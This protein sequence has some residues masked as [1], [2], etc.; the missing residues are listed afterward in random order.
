MDLSQPERF[1]DAIVTVMGLGRYSQGSGLGVTKWLLRHGAQTVITDLKDPAELQESVD[2]VMEWFEKYRVQY[3]DRT[4]YQ[5]LFILGKHREE[6]FVSV[7]CVV[8]NPG[9]PSESDFASRAKS[10]GVAIESDASLFFRYFPHP[11]IAVTGTR[12]KTTT[13]LLIGEMLKAFDSNAVVTGNIS[14]SPLE[15]LDDMLARQTPTPV[16][17]E[18]SSWMLESM[19]SAFT[20][21]QKGPDIAVITN[22]FP[23][24]L[25][26]YADF[27]DYL[28]SKET[29]LAY[30]SQEQ[31]AVLNYDNE[32]VRGLATKVKGKLFW[33]AVTWQDHDGCYVHEG[34]IIFRRNG[35]D[36][37]VIPVAALGLQGTQTVE[38][39]LTA[40]CAALLRGVTVGDVAQ[41]LMTF[42]GTSQRRE[43]VREVDEIAY[44]NDSAATTPEEAIA[45]LA[46]FGAKRD[47]ILIAGGDGV[48]SDCAPLL[49]AI[50]GAC[51]YVVLLPGSL[52]DAL[53]EKLP[54]P[55]ERVMDVHE[56][57]V[58]ARQAAKRGNIV[59]L[60]PGATSTDASSSFVLGEQ[61]RDAVR[62]L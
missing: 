56:A 51:K 21:M 7:D 9:V 32:A 50:Q 57:V 26:R 59:V 31:F 12:A 40:T 29:M 54:T 8:Q 13:T 44:V 18:F 19:P 55:T 16:V 35:T 48:P 25:V 27:A 47:V 24:H 58:K 33:C 23:D 1:Q 39:V 3:P 28:R 52:S 45:T 20:A 15:V 6:D 53:E 62:T 37:V 11:T 49:A 14:V 42:T 17:V 2:M 5:P 38:N 46:T 34:N 60:C 4:L 36:T 61:F 22:A 43:L 10:L 41:V 30:Q